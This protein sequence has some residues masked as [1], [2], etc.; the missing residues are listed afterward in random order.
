MTVFWLLL[1]A[2]TKNDI[3][4]FLVA[5]ALVWKSFKGEGNDQEMLQGSTTS[6]EHP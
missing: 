4:F 5:L 3:C 2:G 1:D 6:M